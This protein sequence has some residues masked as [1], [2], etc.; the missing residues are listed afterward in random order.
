MGKDSSSALQKKVL[1]VGHYATNNLGDHA[2]GRACLQILLSARNCGE[3]FLLIPA[4]F[5]HWVPSSVKLTALEPS[6]SNMLYSWAKADIII[7]AGGTFFQNYG[8]WRSTR[9]ALTVLARVFAARLLGKSVIF[10]G[11]SA[12]PFSNHLCSKASRILG[13]SALRL[14]SS[15]WFRDELS[16]PRMGLPDNHPLDRG[17]LVLSLRPAKPSRSP[18]LGL[19]GINLMMFHS[20]SSG[21]S[22]K[23]DIL[24]F[25]IGTALLRTFESSLFKRGKFFSF[26]EDSHFRSDFAAFTRMLELVPKLRE[27]FEDLTLEE[28]YSELDRTLLKMAECECFLAYRLHAS[29]LAYVISLPFASVL[30]HPKVEGF[31]LDIEWP[32]NLCIAPDQ[33]ADSIASSLSSLKDKSLTPQVLPSGSGVRRLVEDDL[34]SSGLTF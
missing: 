4:E 27:Y 10:A 24:L 19:I 32:K 23:D 8:T 17:D 3:V 22:K 2:L 20:Q 28:C 16:A 31:C 18:K 33:S 21:E 34:K 30:Y 7:F 25:N 29:I 1:Q 15:F 11:G 5:R 9:H 14:A 26:Q 12:G 13:R 6:F